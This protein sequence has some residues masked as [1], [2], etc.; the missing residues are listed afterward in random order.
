MGWPGRTTRVKAA[1]SAINMSPPAEKNRLRATSHGTSIRT[2]TVD[3]WIHSD[4]VRREEE[5]NRRECSG[6]GENR[7]E[8]VRNWPV[9]LKNGSGFI[10]PRDDFRDGGRA[11]TGRTPP[12]PMSQEAE[13]E[14]EASST[15][16]VSAF[17]KEKWHFWR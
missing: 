1:D 7:L 14:P 15:Q 17:G 5:K 9:S 2:R 11:P 13:A 8:N 10:S 12:Q 6:F 16:T 4:P 3:R